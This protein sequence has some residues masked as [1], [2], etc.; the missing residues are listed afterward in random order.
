MKHDNAIA[1]LT[2]H[3]IKDKDDIQFLLSNV[4]VFIEEGRLAMKEE[5]ELK[6]D[7]WSGIAPILRLIHCFL[8][9][10]EIKAA[11]QLSFKTMTREELDG[12]KSE[13]FM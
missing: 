3:P 9:D 6:I 7:K 10:D 1:W 11:L 5:Q 12:R 2:A 4:K 13:E 8:E